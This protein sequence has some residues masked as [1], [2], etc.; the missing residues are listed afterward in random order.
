[1]NREMLKKLLYKSDNSAV[2]TD[3]HLSLN[4]VIVKARDYAMSTLFLNMPGLDAPCGMNTFMGGIIGKKA[5]NIAEEFLMSRESL[6]VAVGMATLKSILPG[7]HVYE[8]GNAIDIYRED[9]KT[10]PTCFIGHFEQAE[11]WR[12]EG[13]PVNII[14]LFP[15]PG[16][17]HWNDSH[18][19]LARAEIV[20]MTGLTLVNNTFDEV[21]RRTPMAKKRIIMGPTVPMSLVL[22][23]FGVDHIGVTIIKDPAST[24]T[25]CNRGG[26]SI[27]HAPDGALQKVNIFRERGI[28]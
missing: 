14:E 23:D 12:L 13:D 24:I 22:F 2:I 1:M 28:T 21:I 26:G 18:D 3:I 9:V 20:F 4:W 7:I 5:I 6:K 11:K 19:V 16:D 17:I 8:A 10:C 25:Y 27:A 15:R